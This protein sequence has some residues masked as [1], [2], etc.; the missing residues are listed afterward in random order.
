MFATS[1]VSFNRPRWQTLVMAAVGFWMS[2]SLCVDLLVMPSLYTAGMMTQADFATAGYEMFWL[3][4]R[5]EI[6]CAALALTGLFALRQRRDAFSIIVSGG[7]SRWAMMLAG[8]LLAIA[9]CYTYFLSPEMSALGLQLN[10][11]IGTTVEVP[12][13]MTVMHGVYWGLE[14]LKLLASGALLSLCYRDM[15]APTAEA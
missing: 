12:A 5:V 6:V 3:F 2:A 9:L 10:A 11:E 15:L 4:N 7:R 8:L 1:N 14:V 13:E